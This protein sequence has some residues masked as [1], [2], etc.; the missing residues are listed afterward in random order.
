MPDDLQ[1][2]QTGALFG[3]RLIQATR[4]FRILDQ[5]LKEEMD[6]YLRACVVGDIRLNHKYSVADLAHSTDIWG[7][8]SQKAS[9]LRMTRVNGKLVTCLEAAKKEGSYSLRKKLDAEIKKAYSFFGVTLFGKPTNSTYEKLFTHHLQSAATY[10]QGLSDASSTI[11]LQSMMINGVLS[12]G[13]CDIIQM[14]S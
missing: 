8:I 9:P 14:V 3:S 6:N 10:Y 4:E 2:T 5:E 13:L 11:F 12:V 7:L 1:Y